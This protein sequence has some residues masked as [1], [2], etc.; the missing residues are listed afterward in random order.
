MN[1]PLRADEA[2]MK[3]GPANMQRGVETVGGQLTLTT[4]RI[5]FESHRFNVQTGATELE[6]AEVSS[7]AKCWTR[8]LNLIPLFPNSIEVQTSE[9]ATARFVVMQRESWIEAIELAQE[10]VTGT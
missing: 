4:E 3:E 7:V 8:F 5:V 1:T 2:I 10:K 9:G 6:L